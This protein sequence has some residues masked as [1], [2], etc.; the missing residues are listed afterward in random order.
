MEKKA[1]NDEEERGKRNIAE[2]YVAMYSQDAGKDVKKK[3]NR[4]R[5]AVGYHLREKQEARRESKN[6]RGEKTPLSPWVGKDIHGL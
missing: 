5:Q 4:E 1:G 6:S 3:Q 2:L